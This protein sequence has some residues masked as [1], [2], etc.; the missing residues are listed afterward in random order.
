MAPLTVENL[1]LSDHDTA[2]QVLAVQRAAYRVEADLIGFDGIPQLT[3]SL[4]DLQAGSLDWIGVRDERRRVVAALAFAD[5]DGVIDIDR[6]V[7]SPDS[8]R[9]GYARALISALHPG[10][11]I[12]VSTGLDNRPAHALY[13]SLGFV[14]TCDEEVVPGLMITWFRR[15]AA[16]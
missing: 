3:E 9:S 8:F 2:R 14:R 10:R 16:G 13:E 11:A 7:V 12:A 6:L 15:E 5:K 1:D 4:A